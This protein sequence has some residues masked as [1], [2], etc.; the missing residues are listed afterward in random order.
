MEQDFGQ[1]SALRGIWT[2]QSSDFFH[3]LV[4]YISRVGV[5]DTRHVRQRTNRPRATVHSEGSILDNLGKCRHIWSCFAGKIIHGEGFVVV[6][7]LC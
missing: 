4:V 3:G 1:G 5:Q 7:M 6:T 2:C